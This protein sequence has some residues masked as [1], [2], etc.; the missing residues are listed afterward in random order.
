MVFSAAGNLDH[1]TFVERSRAASSRHGRQ[2]T[3]MRRGAEAS[4]R[5][6]LRNKKS[7]E[8]VQLCLG[9]PRCP[10]PTSGAMSRW[11]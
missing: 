3:R 6:S 10:S 8:Q 4:A 9:V 11:C 7:L 5:I 1:D 2:R